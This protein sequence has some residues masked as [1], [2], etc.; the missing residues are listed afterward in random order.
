MNVE[1]ISEEKLEE[2]VLG[3]GFLFHWSSS[4]FLFLGV[5]EY[6]MD[7]MP[8]LLENGERLIIFWNACMHDAHFDLACAEGDCVGI[9]SF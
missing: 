4:F 5:L 1:S 7:I 3:F 9:E 6:T 8:G 2:F